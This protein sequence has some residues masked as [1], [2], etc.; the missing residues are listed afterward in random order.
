MDLMCL[1]SA[2]HVGWGERQS[3][4]VGFIHQFKSS[5]P[6]FLIQHPT[7]LPC[8]FAS[9]LVICRMPLGPM[10]RSTVMFHPCWMG[11]QQKEDANFRGEGSPR[12]RSPP[13]TCCQV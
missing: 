11:G 9:L 10:T 8:T 5:H 4:G 12:A 6:L 7:P 2:K 3:P 13:S 1:N